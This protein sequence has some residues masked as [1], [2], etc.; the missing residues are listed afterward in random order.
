MWEISL[1]HSSEKSIKFSPSVHGPFWSFLSLLSSW[2]L[3][4]ENEE[5]KPRCAHHGKDT[6]YGTPIDFV[7]HGFADWGDPGTDF[8]GPFG[9]QGLEFVVFNGV[10]VVF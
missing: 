9:G 6:G 5:N 7:S 10:L 3:R 4:E 8:P 1:K 2:H